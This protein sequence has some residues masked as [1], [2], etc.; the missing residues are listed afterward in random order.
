MT[1]IAGILGILIFILIE[2]GPLGRKAEVTP[3]TG[4]DIA[5]EGD[6]AVVVNEHRSHVALL[7]TDGFLRV[8]ST[9]DG[10]TAVSR[11]LVDGDTALLHVQSV[12]GSERQTLA[13]ST[14][15]GQVLVWPV[16]WE[17]SFD[18]Q[19]R[20]V[21]PRIPDPF[22]FELDP[23]KGPV[24]TFSARLID[25]GGAAVAG[26]LHDGTLVWC[27]VEFEENSMTGEVTEAWSRNE[28][29]STGLLTALVLDG[30]SR[31][32][33]G[34]SS[35][36]GLSAWVLNDLDAGP[37]TV[38]GKDTAAITALSLLIGE[39]SL[40]AGRADGSLEVWFDVRG[41]DGTQRLTPIREF[42][43]QPGAIR[44][45]SP[46]TRN[47]GFL[48]QDDTG[49]LGLYY[50]TSQRVLWTG[51]SPVENATGLFYSPKADGAYAVGPRRLAAIE[52]DNPHPEISLRALFGRVWYEGYE[53][54]DFVWQST[55][56]TDEFEPKLS[57]TP[58]IVGTLKGTLYSLVLAIPLGVAGAMYTSQFMSPAYKSVV[59]PTVEIMAALPSVVLGFLAGLWLAPRLE[60]VFVALML[61]ALLL[62]L[63]TLIMWAS[64]RRLPAAIRD[65]FGTGAEL[66]PYMVALLL[67]TWCCLQLAP[68][69]EG[70]LFGGDFQSWLLETTGL[71]YDQRNAIVVG[72]AMGFAVIPVIF[73]IAEDA[74]SN[75]PRNLVT[76]SLAL[77]A[78][79]WQTVTRVVLP[80]ASPGIF[81]AIMIGF[82]RAV[83]ETMI[84]L[85][86]TGN[87]P[88]LDCNPFNG[89]RTLSANI[90][91]EIP[92]APHGDT[93]YRLLFLA[94]LLLFLFTFVINTVAELI[95][96][97]LHKR[98]SEI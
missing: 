31:I 30:D 26:Q 71:R 78:N 46:S 39:R 54:P 43:N 48:A 49:H 25:D 50:S 76:G 75:V 55:G 80:T 92:E 93:L 21:T 86:A 97:R 70:V 2:V 58:L 19:E 96:Q 51:N 81:S 3:G 45:I 1:I 89:F 5:A 32:L 88:V 4:V 79:R 23:A 60:Q 84:V 52:I 10:E 41:D 57:L 35:S 56:G 94:A 34:G 82:G 65:W 64:L 68:D 63:S 90:A 61:M 85:M 15:T 13:A 77:G 11:S 12:A 40:I 27:R 36:G 18:E 28:L 6:V 17:I 59:K 67:A 16:S 47:K 91:V 73:A 98:Y 74:F 66:L 7:S 42:P 24:G 69:V 53:K 37:T 38:D 8:L 9:E 95:R 62:P 29:E 83:G 14:T 72:L 22:V 33:Y 20:I 44:L 87:T